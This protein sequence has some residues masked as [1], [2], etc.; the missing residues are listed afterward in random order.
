[1][2]YRIITL[3]V[4]VLGFALCFKALD[5]GIRVKGSGLRIIAEGPASDSERLCIADFRYTNH[6]KVYCIGRLTGPDGPSWCRQHNG[7]LYINGRQINALL[8]DQVFI[9]GSLDDSTGVELEFSSMDKAG[10][11]DKLSNGDQL[12]FD[13]L[14]EIVY[15]GTQSL[16]DKKSP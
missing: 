1:M 14:K 11:L 16:T 9:Y 7:K 5:F 2:R 13:E 3:M 6:T 8:D 15:S 10:I 12:S 4:V